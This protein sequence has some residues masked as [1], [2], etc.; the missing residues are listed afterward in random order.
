MCPQIG[1]DAAGNP[2]DMHSADQVEP[3]TRIAVMAYDDTNYTQDT[4]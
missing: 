2:L 3:A 4:K 1:C